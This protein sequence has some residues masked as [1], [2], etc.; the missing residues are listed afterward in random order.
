M[1]IAYNNFVFFKSNKFFK[2]LYNSDYFINY[3][4]GFIRRGI[5]GTLIY[6]TCKFFNTLPTSVITIYYSVLFFVVS[7]IICYLLLKKKIPIYLLFSP[8]LFLSS[9]IYFS[10]YHLSKDLEIIFLMYITFCCLKLKSKNI[11]FISLN[12]L[13]IFAT[14]VHE[15]YFVFIFFPLFMMWKSRFVGFSFV[16]NFLSFSFFLLPSLLFFVILIYFFYGKGNDISLVYNS[17]KGIDAQL[18]NKIKFNTGLFDGKTRYLWMSIN[19]KINFIG[20]FANVFLNAIFIYLL[21]I[22]YFKV[23][24]SKIKFLVIVQTFLVVFISFFA[25][26]FARWILLS[27]IAILFY[28]FSENLESTPKKELINYK[29]FLLIIF[30]IGGL[31]Y[32]SWN[33]YR[34]TF[35]NVFFNLNQYFLHL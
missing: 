6:W 29:I 26:D 19:N 9:F 15:I 4:S 33:I 14:A 23:N 11:T 5:D 30:L 25:S 13:V 22:C 8:F 18:Y 20:F 16:K 1:K 7:S 2:I 31:P 28:L 21:S 27:N 10:L 24:N 17:W 32:I 35:T 3:S 12:F 34:Y